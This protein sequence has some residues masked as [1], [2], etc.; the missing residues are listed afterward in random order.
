MSQKVCVR[1]SDPVMVDM[2]FFGHWRT[3]ACDWERSNGSN[4]TVTKSHAV[5]EFMYY[6]IIFILCRSGWHIMIE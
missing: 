3:F 6:E 2:K 4:R 5:N 1:D